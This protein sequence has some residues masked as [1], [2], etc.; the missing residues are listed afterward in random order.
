MLDQLIV[1]STKM[2]ANQ[3]DDVAKVLP[4]PVLLL[5]GPG[6]GKT[7]Q[8]ARRIKFLIEEGNIDPNKITVITFTGEAARNMRERLS[9]DK[10]P[11]VYVPPERQPAN[12]RTMH[13]LGLQIIA[14][15]YRKVGLRKDFLLVAQQIRQLLLEDSARISGFS[16]EDA[17]QSEECRRHGNCQ[18]T[19]EKKCKICKQ[20]QELLSGLNAIDYDAQIFLAC[21]LLKENPALL[22]KWQESTRHLLV[23]EYQDIN[24]AQY[25][26]I[27]LLCQGQDN[28]LFVVGDDDQSIYSWRGASP[29]YTV[30][31]QD[32][33]KDKARVF[34]L[35]ECRRCPPHVL[36]A[37]LAFVSRNNPKRLEK[38]GLHSKKESE[39]TKVTVYMVPSDKY[40]A[41]AICHAIR[42]AP[43]NQDALV[44]VPGHRFT[45][46][47]KRELRKQR[48]PYDCKTNVA[49]SGLYAI[50]DLVNWL[51]NEKDNF[52]LRVCLERIVKNPTLRIP[53]DKNG[54]IQQRRERTLAKVAPLWQKVISEE[55][56]LYDVLRGTAN[57]NA[58]L[59]FIVD[60]L[61]ELR[62][63]WEDQK[64]TG[65][66]FKTVSRIIR[67]WTSMHSL[68]QE[69]QDWVQDALA[70]DMSSGEPVA[71]VLTMQAAKGLGSDQVFVIGL[72]KGIFPS[73]E[74]KEHELREK[75]RLL[76]VSMTRAKKRLHMFCA[77]T[78]EGKFSYQ[79]PADGESI[80]KLD[81]SPFLDWLPQEH[82]QF[83]EKWPKK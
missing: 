72:N 82:V 34:T 51:K 76:Y 79:P 63:A 30:D 47:I 11:D 37:A 16:G 73:G 66:F 10:Q 32:H 3:T 53:F 15:D 78:R 64:N 60:S 68:S 59:K 43:L 39:T 31:F 36:N 50:N 6:T 74:E 4:G 67:P 55:M 80:A 52:A 81:P 17:Q 54:G 46:P 70:R 83:E 5:A 42:E 1:G 25:E 33:F 12:I 77:R 7:H 21:R 65:R 57:G 75:Q 41:R 38:K 69:V 58:D 20:Y 45:I 27:R 19:E 8:L 18:E 29:T 62:N 71:R 28:G 56:T 22:E 35:N 9:D 26:F 61:A 23:D 14:G 24:H 13:S 44:L 49:D 40:E 2:Q 48:I